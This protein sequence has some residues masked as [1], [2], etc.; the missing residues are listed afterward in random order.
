MRSPLCVGDRFLVNSSP[1]KSRFMSIT[2]THQ[3]QVNDDMFAF[4]QS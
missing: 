2:A 4:L 1:A 3:D